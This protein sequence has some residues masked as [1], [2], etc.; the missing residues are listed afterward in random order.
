MMKKLKRFF[1]TKKEFTIKKL[2]EKC[3]EQATC[4]LN[5]AGYNTDKVFVTTNW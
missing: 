3:E 5:R 2:I 4:A 1:A